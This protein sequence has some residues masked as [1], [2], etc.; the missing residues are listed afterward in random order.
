MAKVRVHQS[1]FATVPKINTPRSTFDRSHV[2][3]T[4]FDAG[5]LIPIFVDEALPGDSWKVNSTV[6]ARLS[7]PAVPFMDNLYFNLQFYAVPMRLVWEHFINMCG[8]QEDPDDSTDYLVPQ[9]Q[10]VQSDFIN[11]VGGKVT[12][13]GSKC[14][15]HSLWDYFGLPTRKPTGTTIPSVSMLYFR[16]YWLIWNQW[17][18]DENLQDS[19]KIDRSDANRLVKTDGDE[20]VNGFSVYYPAPRGKRFDYFTSALRSPQKGT[21]PVLSFGTSAPVEL[22]GSATLKFPGTLQ[23]GSDDGV[24]ASGIGISGTSFGRVGDYP[25]AGFTNSAVDVPISGIQGFNANLT[26]SGSVLNINDIRMAFQV[27]RFLE[28]NARGGTRYNEFLLVQ[29]GVVSPDARLQRAEFLGGFTKMVHVNP[30]VQTSATDDITPQGNLAAY[31]VLSARIAGFRKSF[32][33]HTMIIGVCSVRADLTYQEGINRMWLH[34]SIYDFALPVFAHLGEQP[35]YNKEIFVS[36]AAVDDEAFGYQERYAEYRY[37][38]SVITGK[39]RSSDPQSLDV[40]HL[41]QDFKNL[42]TLSNEFIQDNPP[43]KRVLAVQ[44]EP[45][46]LLDVAFNCKV[47]RCLP[48]YGTPGLVDHY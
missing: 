30:V 5:K 39:F 10:P 47:T 37:K 38:P 11:V 46:F 27:Q 6:F 12:N 48:L 7:T 16:A 21:A 44:D 18:R 23:V 31:A 33:E 1:H 26:K 19:V 22:S 14:G 8:E 13:E 45:D 25:S 36:G 4:T 17:F 9:F 41:S 15:R 28:K 35:I 40:W 29:Y 32:T 34:K 24:T 3:K 2:Y 42:P 43:V 20:T